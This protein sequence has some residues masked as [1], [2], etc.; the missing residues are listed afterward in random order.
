MLKKTFKTTKSIIN[1]NPQLLHQLMEIITEA[2]ITY[3]LMQVEAG[4]DAFQIFDTW[5]GK[6]SPVQFETMCKP[7]IARILEALK[8]KVPTTVFCKGTHNFTN[9]LI[10]LPTSAISVDFESSIEEISK[11]I[12]PSISLQ[13]N[14]DPHLLLTDAA[15]ITKEVNRLLAFA[16]TRPGYIFNLG[17]GILPQTPLENV[18]LV[19]EM[20]KSAELVYA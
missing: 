11:R 5:A 17:H 9:S 15:T 18:Q 19:V 20:V 2:T 3:A 13:G 4:V 7:Y 8:G 6:L 1:N 14:F 12:P 10:E 16:N